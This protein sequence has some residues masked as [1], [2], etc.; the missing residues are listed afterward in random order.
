MSEASG[1]QR[2][3]VSFLR[4]SSKVSGKGRV[5]L[6][7]LT[8]GGDGGDLYSFLLSRKEMLK[9]KAESSVVWMS[10][11][12]FYIGNLAFKIMFTVSGGF[13]EVIRDS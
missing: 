7:T 13:W 2:R 9:Q 11:Q 12:S 3:D 1:I 8:G 6:R 5:R 10:T 4:S